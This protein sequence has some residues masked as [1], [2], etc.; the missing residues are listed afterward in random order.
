MFMHTL[1]LAVVD[2]QRAPHVI[3]FERFKRMAQERLPLL[4]PFRRRPLK[5]PFP[6]GVP[7]WIEEGTFDVDYHIQYKKL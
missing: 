1:K 6:L 4:L 2:A 7:V 3:D 5:A